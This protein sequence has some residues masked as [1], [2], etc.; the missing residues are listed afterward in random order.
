MTVRYGVHAGTE[1]AGIQDCVEFWRRVEGLGYEWLSVWDHFY[2]LAGDTGG[3]GSF[4]ALASHTALACMTTRPRI[5][6]LVYSVA[7]RHPAV[8]ANAISTIDHLSAGRAEV[9]RVAVGVHVSTVVT[10]VD[11]PSVGRSNGAW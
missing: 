1:G 3:R 8:M 10:N 9:A 5:G 6:V 7:Y 11:V 2:P 4:D